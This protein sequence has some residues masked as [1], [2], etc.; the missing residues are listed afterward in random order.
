MF[1]FTEL[2][3]GRREIAGTQHRAMIP[4]DAIS[5]A[6]DPVGAEEILYAEADLAIPLWYRGLFRAAIEIDEHLSPSVWRLMV[7]Y[8]MFE[9]SYSFETGGGTIHALRSLQTVR[10]FGTNPPDF[11]GV[12]GWD[13]QNIQGTD[14]VVPTYNW[15]ETHRFLPVDVPLQYKLDLARTTGK[16]NSNP[17]RGFEEGEVLFLGAAGG[18]RG[19]DLVEI[20]FRFAAQP[21]LYRLEMGGLVAEDEDVP[22]ARGWDYPWAY[23]EDTVHE[24]NGRKLVV[25]RAR[26]ISI[27]RMYESEDFAILGIGV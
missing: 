24:N 12:V 25:P 16:T 26:C 2:F 7:T 5:S 15:T 8:E 10:Q 11:K 3:H 22:V 14:V 18:Q 9:S 23:Y 6:G 19:T 4:Y 21:N 17:F 27:E 20:A 13:G 1:T